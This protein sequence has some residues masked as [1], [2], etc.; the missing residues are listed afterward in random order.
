MRF[1]SGFKGLNCCVHN[2]HTRL[3]TFYS[4]QVI[5]QPQ[6]AYNQALNTAIA[7]ILIV[8]R[9]V[10]SYGNKATIGTINLTFMGPCIIRIFQYISNKIQC[11]TVYFIW[12]LLYMFRVVP[13]PIIRSAN[14]CTASGICHTGTATCRYRG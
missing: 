11:Y 1:N 7:S 8:L 3:R 2:G 5:K 12:K 14:N 13:P 4:F 10:Q 9:H 6:N